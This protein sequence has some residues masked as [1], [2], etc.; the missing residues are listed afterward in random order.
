MLTPGS[1]EQER[2]IENEFLKDYSDWTSRAYDEQEWTKVTELSV[3]ELLALR[4]KAAESA[5]NAKC[6]DCPDFLK[7]VRFVHYLCHSQWQRRHPCHSHPY[8][9]LCRSIPYSTPSFLPLPPTSS[10]NSSTHPLTRTS[11]STRSNTTPT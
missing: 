11:N 8:P 4:A 6:L 7:H 5:Q 2:F 9:H 10:P 1:T 3:R